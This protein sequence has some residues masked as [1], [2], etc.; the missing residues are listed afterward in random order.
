M[1]GIRVSEEARSGFAGWRIGLL[2]LDSPSPR[3]GSRELDPEV[4]LIESKLKR[5]F[6]GLGRKEIA[7]LEPSSA[8]NAYFSRFGKA[9]PVVL[10][11][12][13]VAS[14][15]R[16]IAMPDP[17]VRVMFAAELESMILTAGHDLDALGGELRLDL[18]SGT[19]ALP[20]LGGAEK[21][22]PVGDLILRDAEG[23]IASVLLGP[24][25]RTSIGPKTDKSL[26]VVYS[27]PAIRESEIRAHLDRLARL[28]SIACRGV[29]MEEE[30]ILEL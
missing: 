21:F 4:E 8:Y 30:L 9:Y 22:P 11:A 15:G 24:D 23:I 19:E 7:A 6:E 10:Q 3:E 2:P 18:A 20:T 27:P 17:L 16:K 5:D 13:A 14:K 12:E 29:R 25:S 26:F 1:I 28:A